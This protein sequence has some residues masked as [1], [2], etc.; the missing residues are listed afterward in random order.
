[1]PDTDEVFE[2]IRSSDRKAK[3]NRYD[4]D[5]RGFVLADTITLTELNELEPRYFPEFVKFVVDKETGK[6]AI[7]MQV[8][9]S[10]EVFFGPN[11]GNLLGGNIY[12]DGHI[13]YESTLN[14]G[15]N[16]KYWK[17]KHKGGVF[18]KAEAFHGN[19]RIIEDK[20]LQE[21]IDV[22]LFDWVDLSK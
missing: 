13:I 18:S 14:V 4:Y 21:I 1:M 11:K 7:G 9:K 2:E 8:H 3:D 12:R 19:P 22:T 15:E 20:D 10:A 5:H 17:E 6:V 16:L